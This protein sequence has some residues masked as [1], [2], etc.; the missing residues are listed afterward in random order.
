VAAGIIRA[1]RRNRTET[2]LG[3]DARWLLRVHKFFPRFMDRMLARRVRKLYA[4]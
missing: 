2:V 1:V 4:S 3:W